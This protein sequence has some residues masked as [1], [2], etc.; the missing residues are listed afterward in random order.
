MRGREREGEDKKEREREKVR[1]KE[2]K[3]GLAS[4]GEESSGICMRLREITKVGTASGARASVE[5][6]GTHETMTKNLPNSGFC[7]ILKIVFPRASLSLSVSL[8]AR[9]KRRR[10]EHSFSHFVDSSIIRK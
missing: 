2:I 10:R 6:R 3:S 7:A 1:N 5:R 9:S 4:E 8:D